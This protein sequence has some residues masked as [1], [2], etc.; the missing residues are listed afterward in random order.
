[1]LVAPLSQPSLMNEN[2]AFAADW[3]EALG[4]LSLVKPEVQGSNHTVVETFSLNWW[5]FPC[6]ANPLSHA[7]EPLIIL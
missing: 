2:K 1:M 3:S 6:L 4:N 5:I 7:E